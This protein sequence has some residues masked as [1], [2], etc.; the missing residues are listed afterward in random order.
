MNSEVL[1]MRGGFLQTVSWMKRGCVVIRTGW[2]SSAA[3]CSIYLNT[4]YF[5]HINNNFS[6]PQ[7]ARRLKS[8]RRYTNLNA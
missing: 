1:Y 3:L 2:I 4:L 7:M 5:R 6:F 8:Q